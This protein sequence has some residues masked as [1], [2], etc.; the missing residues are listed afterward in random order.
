ML[1][2]I[3]VWYNIISNNKQCH[4]LN[5]KHQKT[6]KHNLMHC[7]KYYKNNKCDIQ[8]DIGNDISYKVKYDRKC[9]KPILYRHKK[10]VT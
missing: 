7:N 9:H 1:N 5:E 6:K 10:K 2:I 3:G 4:V 8:Y